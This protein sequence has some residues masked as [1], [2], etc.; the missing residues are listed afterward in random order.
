MIRLDDIALFV[1]VASL[2]SF[3][4]A[5]RASNL[6]P[7]QASVAVKRLEQAL[8]V[9]LF[10]RTTRTVRLTRKGEQYLPHAREILCTVRTGRDSVH[11]ATDGF[12]GDLFIGVSPDVG[13]GFLS[14][15]L[16]GF[17]RSHPRLRVRLCVGDSMTSSPAPDA[18]LRYGRHAGGSCEVI[19]PRAERVLVASPAYVATYGVPSSIDE[20]QRHVCVTASR[21]REEAWELTTSAGVRRVPVNA[22][23]RSDDADLVRRWALRGM[24]IAFRP[25][26]EVDG[27]LASG[28]LVRVLADV[29]GAPAPLTLSH[30]MGTGAGAVLRGLATWL[31]HAAERSAGYQDEA[32]GAAA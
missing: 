26:I 29:A 12:E 31:R 4:A 5:A 21:E 15:W 19:A 3:S 13:R 22:T 16:A 11:G 32:S 20:L 25:Q 1:G 27:D 24:G 9:E 28:A 18:M 30:R 10:V 14:P 8:G 7:A 23:W 17:H 6:L 2:G